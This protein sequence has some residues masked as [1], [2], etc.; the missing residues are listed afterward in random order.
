VGHHLRP[1]LGVLAEALVELAPHAAGHVGDDPVE[2]LA[3]LLVEVEIPVHQRAQHAAGLR[4]PVG[5]GPAQRAGGRIGLGGRAVLEPRGAVTQRREADAEHRSAHRRVGDL[6]ETPP[7][8]AAFQPHVPRVG[9]HA[10]TGLPR[11]APARA[12]NGLGRTVQL[13]AHQQHRARLVEIGRRIGEV[14]AIGEQEVRHRLRRLEIH[15]DSAP[16][17][18]AIGAGLGSVEPEQGGQLRH[19]AL[20]AARDDRVAVAHQKAVTGVDGRV[21]VGVRTDDRARGVVEVRHRDGVAAVHHVDDH[22]A[23]GARAIDGQQDRH[24]GG[25][26]DA[27]AS[28]AR[29]QVDVGDAP[30]GL[31]RGVDGEAEPALQLLVRSD[32]AERATVGEGTSECHVE[33]GHRHGSDSG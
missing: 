3:A 20:P 21:G 27:A 11:E 28:I 9:D 15:V 18:T 12:G 14:A 30:V 16:Q 22:A 8:E 6:I 29:R 31:V 4:A 33:V 10:P 5:V 17:R 24:V 13:I 26:L 1:V 23:V 25:E 2:G 7:L 19:V 32:V